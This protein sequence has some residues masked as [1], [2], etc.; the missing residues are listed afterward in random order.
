[1]KTSAVPLII[2]C[3]STRTHL[4]IGGPLLK[5]FNAR[6]SSLSRLVST[7]WN[8]R[9]TNRDLGVYYVWFPPETSHNSNRPLS[10]YFKRTEAA[11]INTII[12][13]HGEIR[14]FSANACPLRHPPQRPGLASRYVKCLFTGIT[15]VLCRAHNF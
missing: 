14:P 3:K 10:R 5:T 1:M 2:L 4:Q 6:I 7:P 8:S 11:A 12:Y 13:I 15:Y 9:C